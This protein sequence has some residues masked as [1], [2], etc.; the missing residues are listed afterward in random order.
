[1]LMVLAACSPAAPNSA[2]QKSIV[3]SH[4]VLGALVKDLAGDGARVTVLIPN[5]QDPHD[6]E[7]SARD[8]EA[9]NKADLLVLNGLGLEAH[10][11]DAIE[12]AKARGVK[13]FTGSD[14]IK[15]RQMGEGIHHEDDHDA[16]K[17]HDHAAGDPHY[18]MDPLSMKAVVVAL[19]PQVKA[20]AGLDVA[21]RG[22][23]L[24]GRLDALNTELAGQLNRI[25]ADGRKLVTGHESLGYFAQRYGYEMIGAVVPSITT[26]AEASAADL[27]ALKKLMQ[28][29]KV[30]AL[31]TELGT[32]RAGNGRQSRSAGHPPGTGGQLLLHLHA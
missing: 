30:K 16:K 4:S 8:I 24:A 29:E 17:E 5:G 7:P 27:A 19:A 12:Q 31:F 2:S 9:V 20:A 23:D 15:V 25:P 6:W 14:Y 18:W 26:Q 22:Q 11:H 13:V 21:A 28:A 10:I 32:P 3:V 1:M